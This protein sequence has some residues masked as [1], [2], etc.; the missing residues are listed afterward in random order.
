MAKKIYCFVMDDSIR[1]EIEKGNYA[2]AACYLSSSDAYALPIH[3][4]EIIAVTHTDQSDELG[5]AGND[6]LVDKY[7]VVIDAINDYYKKFIE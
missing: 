6:V 1:E 5:E 2:L 3:E 4:E 7:D